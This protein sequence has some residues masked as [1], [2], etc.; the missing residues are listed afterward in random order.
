MEMTCQELVELVTEYL[1]GALPE[2][3]G[4]RF[5]TH[6]ATCV[7]CVNYLEQVRITVRVVGHLRTRDGRPA[8]W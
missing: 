2:G 8:A 1:E 7:H 5:E 6:L 3:D 4:A